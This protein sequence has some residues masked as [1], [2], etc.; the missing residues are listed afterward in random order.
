M[1]M[2]PRVP[3]GC[4][5]QVGATGRPTCRHVSGARLAVGDV[6]QVAVTVCPSGVLL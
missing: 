5:P 3:P 2:A 6:S 4:P 1:S